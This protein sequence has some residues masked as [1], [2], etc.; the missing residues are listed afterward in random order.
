MY[1]QIDKDYK[2]ADDYNYQQYKDE[3]FYEINPFI[4][5]GK[6]EDGSNFINTTKY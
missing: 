5:K 1:L 4:F 3:Y 2:S 6:K